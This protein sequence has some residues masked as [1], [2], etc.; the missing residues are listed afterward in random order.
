VADRVAWGEEA[1]RTELVPE[2]APDLES[3][4][5]ELVAARRPVREARCQLVHGD[6]TGN[7]LFPTG[8]DP[9]VIDFS[10]YWRPVGFAE[11]VVV[12]DG[13][14]WHDAPSHLLDRNHGDPD[15]AQLL[16]RALVFRLLAGGPTEG[17]ELRRYREI[18]VTVCRRD[19]R[20]LG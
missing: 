14:L 16:L 4:L 1:G 8:G 17:E 5:G 2:L 10:P 15:W 11:A 18:G 19:G 7:V 9:V 3:V 6:L 20:E 13:L 12:V